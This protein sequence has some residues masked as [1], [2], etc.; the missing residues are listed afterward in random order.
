MRKI[1]LVNVD[2]VIPNFALEK[3]RVYYERKGDKVTKIRDESARILPFVNCYNKIYVSCVF[4]YNKHSCKKWEGVADIGGSGYDLRKCLPAKIE[5]IKPKMNFGF[6]TRGCIRNCSWCIVPRK[7]GWIRPV[8]DVYDIWDGQGRSIV[9]MDNNILALP[10]HFL[11]ICRQIKKENLVVDFNQG[12]DH[13]LLTDEICQE[14]LSLRYPGFLRFAFDHISYKKSVLKAIKMLKK[15]G[16]RGHYARWYVYVGVNNT[17]RDVLERINILRDA[18]QMV[19]LMRDRNEKVQNNSEFAKMFL[20]TYSLAS[21]FGVEY[22]YFDRAFSLN[23]FVKKNSR[24][25][26]FE[27][28]RSKK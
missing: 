1:L 17:I 4:D 23:R 20:W 28:K 13:R 10:K 27:N 11:K 24:P 21:Y 26:L 15:N 3:L 5:R 12:L 6:T 8:G 9:L 2:S 14:L 25:T 7:E 18:G 16:M 19:F 22:C